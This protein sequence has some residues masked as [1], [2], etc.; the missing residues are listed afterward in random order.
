MANNGSSGKT[1]DLD[2]LDGA[3]GEALQTLADPEL[4]PEGR[5]AKTL[6]ELSELAYLNQQRRDA[7]AHDIAA[8]T[9]VIREARLSG[10]S[11]MMMTEL[12]KLDLLLR[13]VHARPIPQP[14]KSDVKKE[15][16]PRLNGNN[17]RWSSFLAEG[18]IDFLLAADEL[19]QAVAP[20]GAVLTTKGR[21]LTREQ[22][23]VML[24]PSYADPKV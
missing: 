2:P 9:K 18:M 16:V 21:T 14:S 20:D 8:F 11:H 1:A 23:A 17:P 24:R 19:P 4:T 6:L 15:W 3:V 12:G 10:N 13:K 22:V 7:A 5:T